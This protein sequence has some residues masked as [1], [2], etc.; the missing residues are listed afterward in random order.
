MKGGTEFLQG[1]RWALVTKVFCRS[2]AQ[3]ASSKEPLQP[4]P[5]LQDWDSESETQGHFEGNVGE[6][7]RQVTTHTHTTHMRL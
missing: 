4:E 6:D 5:S 1:L 7:L 2:S 3:K